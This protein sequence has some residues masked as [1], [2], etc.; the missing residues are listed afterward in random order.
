MDEMEGDNILNKEQTKLVLKKLEEKNDNDFSLLRVTLDLTV[1]SQTPTH[2][3]TVMICFYNIFFRFESY[4][5]NYAKNYWEIRF[6]TN[7]FLFLWL[8][9]VSI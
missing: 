1:S 2:F 6:L 5:F 7:Y 3:S 9:R 4:K 8:F